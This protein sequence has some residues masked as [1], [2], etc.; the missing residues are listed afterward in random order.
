MRD[1]FHSFFEKFQEGE[2]LSAI[3]EILPHPDFAYDNLVS[4]E[5]AITPLVNYVDASIF[6]TYADALL[7]NDCLQKAL[8]KSAS[9]KSAMLKLLPF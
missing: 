1:C 2:I 4:E 8:E 3:G 9:W 5:K 6:G 7:T